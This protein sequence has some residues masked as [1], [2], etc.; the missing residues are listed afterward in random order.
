MAELFD[1]LGLL[2]ALEEDFQRLNRGLADSAAAILEAG[3]ALGQELR[4][5]DAALVPGWSHNPGRRGRPPA[6]DRVE[7]L[8]LH[9][10]GL[11]PREIAARLGASDVRVA[12]IIREEGLQPHVAPRV[13]PTARELAA[14]QRRQDI[15]RLHGQ[16]LVPSA[17]A[18]EL[19]VSAGTVYRV[20]GEAGLRPHETPEAVLARQRREQAIRLHQEGIPGAEIARRLGVSEPRVVEILREFRPPPPP[21]QAWELERRAF[22]L[23]PQV[24]SLRRDS[25]EE[26]IRLTELA[27]QGLAESAGAYVA[28][29]P[30]FPR[31]EMEEERWRAGFVRHRAL[32]ALEDIGVYRS[33]QQAMREAQATALPRLAIQ[34][35]ECIDR[36]MRLLRE[37]CPPPPRPSPLLEPA[38][39]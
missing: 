18:A 34:A 17:I 14:E 2:T 16:G 27:L 26:N 30:E 23:L 3:S 9:A 11:A 15:L 36:A 12:Q 32:R 39:T 25:S 37:C 10:Q 7:V 1:P 31:E 19:E 5:L 8:R 6:V 20:L 24:E 35:R 29:L 13:V 22:D 33:C 38:L 4:E 28:S 21:K